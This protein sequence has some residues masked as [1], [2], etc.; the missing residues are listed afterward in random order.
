MVQVC[1]G[2]GECALRT[3]CAHVHMRCADL[4]LIACLHFAVLAWDWPQTVPHR[5]P[6][7]LPKQR[8]GAMAAVCATLCDTTPS[9]GPLPPDLQALPLSTRYVTPIWSSLAVVALWHERA[10]THRPPPGAAKP[11]DGHVHGTQN[12]EYFKRIPEAEEDEL[13]M[14]DLA[15]G[16]TETCVWADRDVHKTL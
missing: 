3:D 7:T 15:F 4:R 13:D 8:T 10:F 16:L 9:H 2:A 6:A 5:A 11:T 12:E 1:R 14:L